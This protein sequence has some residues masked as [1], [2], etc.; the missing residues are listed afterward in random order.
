[1]S[2]NVGLQLPTQLQPCRDA[3]SA[4]VSTEQNATTGRAMKADLSGRQPSVD[5]THI[6]AAKARNLTFRQKLL[7]AGIFRR[8]HPLPLALFAL[9]TGVRAERTPCIAYGILHPTNFYAT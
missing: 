8:H 2:D 4:V 5:G 3:A 7:I 1:M 6:D 9:I